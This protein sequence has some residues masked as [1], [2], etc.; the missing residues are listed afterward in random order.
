[1]IP[2]SKKTLISGGTLDR[3]VLSFTQI[4]Y[5]TTCFSKDLQNVISEMKIMLC[6]PYKE[7]NIISIYS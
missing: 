5:K 3:E 2:R 1:M 7:G 4:C 6:W